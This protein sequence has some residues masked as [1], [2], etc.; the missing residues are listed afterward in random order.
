M[1]A[2][3]TIRIEAKGGG[4]ILVI[5]TAYDSRTLQP[6][7]QNTCNFDRDGARKL[8][9]DICNKAGLPKPW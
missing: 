9:M 4:N 1:K 2:Q 5:W 8:V 6:N 7:H 3:H